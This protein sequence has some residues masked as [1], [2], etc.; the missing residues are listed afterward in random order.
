[1]SDYLLARLLE[2]AK[3]VA[4]ESANRIDDDSEDFDDF[5]SEASIQ[6]NRDLLMSILKLV[7]KG[8]KE[9]KKESREIRGQLS[10]LQKQIAELAK[11]ADQ[12][13]S[14]RHVEMVQKAV[15]GLL[16]LSKL[17]LTDDEVDSLY[18]GE[19]FKE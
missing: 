13:A 3:T 18:D 14:A 12:D 19:E 2:E 4:N 16:S 5:D 17:R 7:R 1:M 9:R 8:S 15:K 10:L 6:D 11:N